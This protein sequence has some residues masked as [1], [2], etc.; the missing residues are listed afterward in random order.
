MAL[1][2]I[3]RRLLPLDRLIVLL[4][5]LGVGAAFYGIGQRPEGRQVI[6]EQQGQT[7]FAAP[8]DTDRRVSLPGPR[9]DTVVAIRNGHAAI[10]EASCPD[11]VCMGMGEVSH[12][13]EV[14]ACVPNG[15]LLHIEGA[16]DDEGKGYDLL[17]R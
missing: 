7:V 14:V 16:P 10:V 4:L 3:W 5:L 2:A 9:G 17:S 1:R 13:G 12:Q 6:V 15:L 8:L 11:K